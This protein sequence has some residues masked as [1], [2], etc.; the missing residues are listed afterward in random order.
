MRA[1]TRETGASAATGL[2]VLP[3]LQVVREHEYAHALRHFGERI[4]LE[5]RHGEIRVGDTPWP[6]V[7]TA[8]KPLDDAAGVSELWLSDAAVR[9]ETRAGLRIACDAQFLLAAA[10]VPLAEH[11]AAAPAARLVYEALTREVLP[12]SA[13]P[14]LLRA[15]NV[16][17]HVNRAEP[18]AAAQGSHG[19]RYRQFCVG[20]HEGIADRI[21]PAQLPA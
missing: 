18:G 21:A 2:S 1:D 3:G 4:L 16:I 10:H 9:H 20:R 7:H 8:L 13:C 19:E 11:A 15:W 14:H 5:V 17:P 12:V 6:R